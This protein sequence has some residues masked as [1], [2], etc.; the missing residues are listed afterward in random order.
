MLGQNHSKCYTPSVTTQGV[1]HRVA[2]SVCSNDFMDYIPLTTDATKIVKVNIHVMQYSASDPRNFRDTPNERAKLSKI[3]GPINGDHGINYF[4]KNMAQPMQ[5]GYNLMPTYF[6]PDSKIQFKLMGVYYHV[7]PIGWNNNGDSQQTYNITKYGVNP[8]NELNIFLV[9]GLGGGGAGTFPFWQSPLCI[10]YDLK[11]GYIDP[12]NEFIQLWSADLQ[13]M[14]HEVG[15]CLGLY[16][17]WNDE[18]LDTPY[19]GGFGFCSAVN[20]A[21]IDCT[22]NMMAYGSPKVWLSPQQVGKSHLTLV[23]Y[24]RNYLN[25]CEYDPNNSTTINNVQTWIKGEAI[26]GD[27]IINPGAA[28][29]IKCEVFMSKH[30]NI[31]VKEGAQ[32]IVDGGHITTECS[33][34]WQGIQ[35]WGNSEKDQ[36]ET[37]SKGRRHQGLVIIRNGSL[38][39]NAEIGIEADKPGYLT[40]GGGIVIVEN[41][42]FRNCWKAI[43]F[44][45]YNKFQSISS[46]SSSTF[47]TTNYLI[48]GDRP[49]TFIDGWNYNRLNITSSTFRNT[50]NNANNINLLGNG[51]FFISSN[52]NIRGRMMGTDNVGDFCNETNPRWKP[53]LFENL[54]TGIELVNVGMQQTGWLPTASISRNYFKNCINGIKAN[55]IPAISIYQN[56][57]VMEKNPVYNSVI[58]GIKNAS[59]TGFALNENC[60]TQVGT[61]NFQAGGIVV[62]DAGGEN[63]DVYRNFS[64]NVQHAFTA[65]GKN[66]TQAT[67]EHKYRG[68]QFLCNENYGAQRYDFVVEGDGVKNNDPM[69][70]IRYYQGGVGISTNAMEAGNLF[71]YS[72]LA[73]ESNFYNTTLN[74]IVYFHTNALN[75]TPLYYSWNFT[76]VQIDIINTCPTMHP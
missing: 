36:N 42:T 32:L 35:V 34:L 73:S 33:N 61:N 31:I 46:I 59:S 44:E 8:G 68:L 1:G 12:T 2:A 53:C 18:F 27:I 7:D 37:D 74:S 66:R 39:E 75:K 64:Y 14:A 49:M 71:T 13:L 51:I 54:N 47:E 25:T 17:T 19:P 57:V 38:I 48:N 76:P 62:A 69:L 63:N 30:S 72:T 3:I 4:F 16:H 23:N 15:H 29:T 26:Q 52:V 45:P 65:N 22:N 58:E 9:R 10:N 5:G 28:L 67:T 6:I 40:N 60:I 20:T 56:K 50:N 24:S 55:G 43:H 70:G 11:N 21:N 41:S